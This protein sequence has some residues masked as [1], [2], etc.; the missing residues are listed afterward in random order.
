MTKIRMFIFAITIAIVFVV[1]T[2]IFLYA[3]GYRLDS[4]T[5]KFSP[6]GLLVIKS[7]PD[8]AQIFIN[9]ELKTATNATIPLIPN[10]YDVSVKKE[11]FLSWNKRLTIEKEIVTEA[12]AHLFKSVPSLSAITFLG[13][14]NPIPSHDLTKISYV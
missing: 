8:G 5:K 2:L 11:G 12:S 1:G 9:G 6:N 4:D 10:T 7:V 3:K 13:V 14:E